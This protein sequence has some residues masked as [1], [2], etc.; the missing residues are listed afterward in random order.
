MRI[1]NKKIAL[2]VLLA[3]FQ[4]QASFSRG[5]GDAGKSP[6]AEKVRTSL[7]AKRAE[8]EQSEQIKEIQQ[9]EVRDFALASDSATETSAAR[10]TDV[11]S[12][13]KQGSKAD[14]NDARE[15]IAASKEAVSK[16][17]KEVEQ[18]ERQ[19]ELNNLSPEAKTDIL[20]RLADAQ[21]RLD[22]QQDEL[23]EVL[24]VLQGR[25]EKAEGKGFIGKLF[26]KGTR[27]QL[28][29]LIG[30]V[31]TP[32]TVHHQL[33]EVS[34]ALA[35]ASQ[36][37]S[38]VSAKF[39][40]TEDD[41]RSGGD[42][43]LI[44]SSAH[45]HDDNGVDADQVGEAQAVAVDAPTGITPDATDL[46]VAAQTDVVTAGGTPDIVPTV[47]GEGVSR[48]GE[49]PVGTDQAEA[50]PV[51][52]NGTEDAI[53]LDPAQA[54]AS[55]I[56]LL[57]NEEV[58]AK[59]SKEDRSVIENFVRVLQGS[60]APTVAEASPPATQTQ[61]TAAGEA[62]EAAPAAEQEAE[63]KVVA[64]G[65]TEAPK[66]SELQPA[67]EVASVTPLTK[68]ELLDSLSKTLI[69]E[70][71]DADKKANFFAR[72]DI[73]LLD[74]G[75]TTIKS[76]F[77]SWVK[78][79]EGKCDAFAARQLASINKCS[80]EVLA[81]ATCKTCGQTLVSD[82]NSSAVEEANALAEIFGNKNK[83]TEAK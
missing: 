9:Q 7:K 21:R 17:S 82:Q 44:A 38:R 60:Q 32:G 37:E 29:A 49:T 23:R 10:L 51:D 57:S 25:Q 15:F 71:S 45:D 40:A 62:S 52:P 58:L 74:D 3:F 70:L 36:T 43:P 8:R 27:K 53:P 48:V 78:A 61:V 66:E 12:R 28:D 83:V 46:L 68:A 77:D 14:R 76:A 47:G 2:L 13:K 31:G 75:K 73:S 39:D 80:V 63:E 26:N 35:L 4:A 18:L 67:Q 5:P 20:N 56:E 30:D 33:N 55:F 24:A 65:E 1:N 22:L 79:Q 72:I 69:G 41:T 19:S 50:S 11:G 34:T 59:F 54:L 42:H 81:A 6:Q 16:I 64:A